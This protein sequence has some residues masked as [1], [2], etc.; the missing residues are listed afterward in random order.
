MLLLSL[1]LLLV[2][3]SRDRPL[4]ERMVADCDISVGWMHSGYPVGKNM[5]PH[6]LLVMLVMQISIVAIM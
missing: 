1:P 5:Q 3:F 4:A 6:L 2:Q